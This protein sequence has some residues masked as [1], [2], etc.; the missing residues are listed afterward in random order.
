MGYPSW[1]LISFPDVALWAIKGKGRFLIEDK[2]RKLS[3][4]ELTDGRYI[5]AD[6]LNDF[7]KMYQKNTQKLLECK[8]Y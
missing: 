8:K 5:K 3:E 2:C 1:F 4:E 7:I 6:L